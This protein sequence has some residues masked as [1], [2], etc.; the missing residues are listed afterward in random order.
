MRRT[1][2]EEAAMADDKNPQ[3]NPIA[4]EFQGAEVSPI[5]EAKEAIIKG[6]LVRKDTNG[7]IEGA[8]VQFTVKTTPATTISFTTDA[9]GAFNGTF[10]ASKLPDGNV[11]NE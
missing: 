4:T 8:T 9:T 3:R 1:R 2:Q 10:D 11:D 6:R 5:S 7:G